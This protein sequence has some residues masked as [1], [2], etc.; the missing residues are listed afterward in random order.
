MVY[1]VALQLSK[2]V[3]PQVWLDAACQIFF[4]FSLACGGLIA[5]ASYNA[6]D[7]NCKRDVLAVSVC[8]VCT[9]LF[10]ASII[11][12]ILGH[13]AYNQFNRCVHRYLLACIFLQTGHP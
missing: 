9:A 10:A 1:C 6:E 12:S 7:Y 13:K 8:N 3:D 4:S 11:F 2:L 5:F